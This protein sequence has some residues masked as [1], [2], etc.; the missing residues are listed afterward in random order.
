MQTRLKLL[1]YQFLFYSSH[2]EE[3]LAYVVFC[4]EEASGKR[5]PGRTITDG[6]VVERNRDRG[7]M[8]E[9]IQSHGNFR[10][11][12]SRF[13]RPCSTTISC[14]NRALALRDTAM[15]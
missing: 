13:I 15:Q 3:K 14:E 5:V 9:L 1:F 8:K 2:R 7:R 11:F 4:E 6:K 12:F 10:D